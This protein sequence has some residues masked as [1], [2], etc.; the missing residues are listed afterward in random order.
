[1]AAPSDRPV[2]FTSVGIVH[3]NDKDAARAFT[4]LQRRIA[5]RQGAIWIQ[6]ATLLT[7]L[8]GADAKQKEAV[9]A[10]QA[11]CAPI[12]EMRI[13]FYAVKPRRVDPQWA[14]DDP[15]VNNPNIDA[16]LITAAGDQ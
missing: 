15:R 9:K 13:T 12:P 8:V 7:E 10:I 16:S 4:R 1:M 14:L 2:Q 3:G 6:D 11:A 5:K